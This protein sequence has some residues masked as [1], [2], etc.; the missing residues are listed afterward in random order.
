MKKIKVESILENIII[1]FLIIQPIF[2]LK[3]FYNSIST[4]IRTT[5]III[6]FLIYFIKSNNRKKYFLLIYPAILGIYEIFH[7]INAM[8]FTSVVPGDFNYSLVKELLYFVK[9][10]VPILLI[11]VLFKS[12]ITNSGIDKIIQ[13]IVFTMSFIIIVTNLLGISYGSYSDEMIKANF[14]KWFNNTENY[15]Y[16]DLASKGLFEYGNQIGAVLLMFL[17]FIIN[18]S[19]KE[20]NC[21]NF[22]ILFMNVVALILLGTRVAVIG[23]MLVFIYTTA[24]ILYMKN[25]ENLKNIKIKNFTGVIIV[26]IIYIAILPIN[27]MCNRIYEMNNQYDETVQVDSQNIVDDEANGLNDNCVYIENNNNEE[28]SITENTE[29]EELSEENSNTQKEEQIKYIQ[30]N[31]KRKNI[32]E[33]F[34]LISYP[35]QYDTEFWTNILN[36]D[37]YN[38]TNYRY[39]EK[40]MVKRIIEINNNKYDK[41]FGITHIRVQNIFNIEQDFI[42]QYYALGILGCIIIFLPYFVLISIYVYQIIKSKFKLCSIDNLLSIITIFMIFG[43]AYNS[44]NLLNSLSFTIYFAILY[45]KLYNVQ[46]DEGG[47]NVYKEYL[48]KFKKI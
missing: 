23:I 45:Y 8:N 17:P 7:H 5:V 19:V 18:K 39:L 28:N 21:G 42:E 9:M 26:V 20:K 47:E 29:T 2:D 22:A 15:T 27:P 40:Q 48:F 13:V 33:Q 11:Y 4:L 12:K 6:I 34:I 43:I 36:L 25:K 37:I 38:R 32:H 10:I 44:G 3:I 30:D 41:I 31:Y 24:I 46:K 1:I 14:I 35:Y 16:K